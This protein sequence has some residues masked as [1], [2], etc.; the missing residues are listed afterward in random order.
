MATL[1]VQSSAVTG[2]TVTWNS[3]AAGG[4]DFTNN[5][6]TAIIVRNDDV[7][8]TNV[9][10]VTSQVM[11]TDLAIDDRVVAV[12]A[13]VYKIIG[14][15]PQALYGST[16]NLTYSSETSLFVAIVQI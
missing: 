13:S 4:D 5:G 16:I 12:G 1:T 11:E 8:S 9:T 2:T 7:S 3:A 10:I 14:P 15:F 6:S